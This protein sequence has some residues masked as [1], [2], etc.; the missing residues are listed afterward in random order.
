MTGPPTTSEN[1]P[2][3]EANREEGLM[4]EPEVSSTTVTSTISQMVEGHGL[5]GRHIHGSGEL[6]SAIKW[7]RE[8]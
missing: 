7:H 6:G 3:P 4:L 5:R 1:V 2:P 8:R